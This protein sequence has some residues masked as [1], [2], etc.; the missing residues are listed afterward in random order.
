MSLPLI[1]NQTGQPV[2][3]RDEEVNAAVSS[4]VYS[5]AP[6]TSVPVQHPETGE[7]VSVPSENVGQLFKEGYTL[8]SLQNI[9]NQA[10]QAQQA[11]Q[12]ELLNSATAKGVAATTGALGMYS[13]GA[14]DALMNKLSPDTAK[15]V[16]E[17]QKANP[18]STAIGQGAGLL[19]PMGAGAAISGLGRAV[20]G[21]GKA[22][23]IVKSGKLMEE[24]AR[25]HWGTEAAAEVAAQTAAAAEKAGQGVV[26]RAISNAI[27]TYAGKIAGKAANQA[28]G[29][30]IEGI[31]MAGGQ[32]ISEASLGDPQEVASNLAGNLAVGAL[33]GGGLGAGMEV[34]KPA[35]KAFFDIVG[36][37]AKT[38]LGKV[39]GAIKNTTFGMMGEDAA[40]AAKSPRTKRAQELMKEESAINR[41][42]SQKIDE[43]D[44]AGKEAT[45]QTKNVLKSVLSDNKDAERLATKGT[46]EDLLNMSEGLQEHGNS[47]INPLIT[48]TAQK[49]LKCWECR[50]LRVCYGLLTIEEKEE[51]S[52]FKKKIENVK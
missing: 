3:V 48:E 44:R 35:F 10:E 23:E 43:L 26:G 22:G 38:G 15:L 14:T 34:A 42:A 46:L 2:D 33:F 5:F 1:N 21:A 45:E 12:Q 25:L 19:M 18:W 27:P 51:C 37:G 30:A 36:R 31:L 28:L 24:A 49:E 4:G 32:A 7:V 13:F 16:G 11:R 20:T 17:A 39:E 29:S 52:N 47:K 6:N 8:P 40:A 41:T 9:S 50:F